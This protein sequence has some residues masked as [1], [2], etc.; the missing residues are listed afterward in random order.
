MR[1]FC[2]VTVISPAL[3]LAGWIPFALPWRRGRCELPRGA[4]SHRR[5]LVRLLAP[6]VGH[7]LEKFY[8][9]GDVV[10]I[11]NPSFWPFA[12]HY[13]RLAP[14]V[15]YHVFDN[16][17]A[18]PFI[19]LDQ[20]VFVAK[21]V[22]LVFAVSRGIVDALQRRCGFQLPSVH[23]IP[24]GFPGSWLPPSIPSE[25][26]RL[27]D[28]L[29]EDF[30]PL[31]GVIG[32][33]SSRVDLLPILAAHD[34]LPALRWLFIG[35]VYREVPGLAE[36][37]S[38]PRCRFLGALPYETLQPYFATLDAALLPLTDDD[39]NP[40]SSPVR[41]FSQLPTGQPILY[42]G[43]C[44]QIA[45]TPSLAYHCADGQALTATL[46]N[47][48]ATGF[49]DGRA[50]ERHRFAMGCTWDQRAAAIAQALEAVLEA[51]SRPPAAR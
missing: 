38:S 10:I 5:W 2:D 12:I 27:P 1:G 21:H 31:I 41:F 45:E 24:N 17:A 25:R 35:P 18:Y 20:E 51:R 34:A 11:A 32:V 43:T 14:V 40:C 50:E 30:R 9:R 16:Y 13:R 39:I 23:V 49:D 33:I 37:Q 22:D 3:T 8:G 48:A 42:T 36:L 19:R 44:A 6:L 47:L 26:Q 15:A 4:F 7:R 28:R 46:K 29:S